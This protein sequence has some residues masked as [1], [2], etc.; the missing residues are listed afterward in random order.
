MVGPS[1][2]VD[3]TQVVVH[4]GQEFGHLVALGVFGT[5]DGR[6]VPDADPAGLILALAAGGEAAPIRMDVHREDGLRLLRDPQRLQQLHDGRR[7]RSSLVLFA[8]AAE[9]TV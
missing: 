4:L 6:H 9:D 3:A 2:A 8:A 7:R 1:E 5:E